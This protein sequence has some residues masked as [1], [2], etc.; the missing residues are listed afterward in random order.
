MSKCISITVFFASFLMS[1]VAWAADVGDVPLPAVSEV[2]GKLELSGGWGGLNTFNN[3][4][5]F[6]GGA[7]ISLP[8]A[9][10]FGLQFDVA[11]VNAF[12]DNLVGAATHLFTRD[13]HAFL[14]GAL[15]GVAKTNNSSFY[16]IGPEA[17]LYMNNVSFE[18]K[19]GY[20]DLNL[21]GVQSNQLFAI[22][23]VGL[24]ATDD[25]RFTVGAS[26][27]A[28]FKSGRLGM[29]WMLQ[30]TGMPMSLTANARYG[31]NNF[32]EATAGIKIYFGGSNKSLIRRHREDDPPNNALDIFDAAG[33]AFAPSTPTCPSGELLSG[34]TCVTI[35]M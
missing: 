11:D 16:Y 22:G 20:L 33:S 2:N 28:G 10:K 17:E 13:P 12:G 29:E 25:L 14:F 8:L 9:E 24:Y 32:V 31:D 7:S 30:N 6:R 23:D 1:S 18:V 27:V 26:S 35:L 4:A 15:G 34:E 21:A 3:S 19:G 5:V